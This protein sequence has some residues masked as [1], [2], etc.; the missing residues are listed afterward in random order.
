M[1]KVLLTNQI[2]KNS[3]CAIGRKHQDYFDTAI[4]GFL[5]EVRHTG[6]KTFYIRYQNGRGKTSQLKLAD[7]RDVSLSQARELARNARNNIAMGRDPCAEKQEARTMLT[8]SEFIAEHYL[9]Y[10][11]TYK[12]SWTTDVSLLKNHLL[13]R[14][15]DKHLDIITRDEIIKMHRDCITSGGAAGSANRLLIMMRFIFNLA[16]RWEIPGINHNPCARIPLLELNNKKE[17]YL[18]VEEAGRLYRSVC[19]SK[20]KMLRFI[21]SML[22]VTGARKREVLDAK[23]QDFD[24][25]RRLWRIPMTKSGKPRHVPLADG[26]LKVLEGLPRRLDTDYV[27]ANPK[28][29]KPFV[30]VFFAWDTAR[31]NAD[32]SDVRM[33]DLRHS[34]A[35]ILVN[36]GRTLYEVQHILG[37]T[38]VKTTQRYAH[39]SQD[40]L[41]D[42]ANAATRAMGAALS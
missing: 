26:A 19:K 40:T 6:G 4:K 20:N 37:H 36:S 27:F 38:Q 9:P 33:H 2:L 15:A 31:K 18:S 30:S 13:P 28:T 14:F 12:R 32:L 21:V 25:A 35:S 3:S 39:L 17:R 10:I 34:F 11:K 16:L 22:L 23:W 41:L 42:A 8:F 29:N 7:W 5:L 1:T 24:I